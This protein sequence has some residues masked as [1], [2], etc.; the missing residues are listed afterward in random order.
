MESDHTQ[1][2]R[3]ICALEKRMG[4]IARLNRR[5][6]GRVERE[7]QQ[8]A[9]ATEEYARLERAVRDAR[10]HRNRALL[11]GKSKLNLKNSDVMRV[12]VAI[13]EAFGGPFARDGLASNQLYE[14][15][16]KAVPDI[17][18][19]TMR[20]HLHRFKKRR[21]LSQIGFRWF[22]N[23]PVSAPKAN[24]AR[25]EESCAEAISREM[26]EGQLR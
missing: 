18:D 5:R 11:P 4:E 20:S 24:H 2:T 26:R 3:D 21:A 12:W 9:K 1:A 16:R 23:Q 13:Q 25:P 15:M 7:Q 6:Q 22:L 19:S 10:A 17:P 14:A 8:I